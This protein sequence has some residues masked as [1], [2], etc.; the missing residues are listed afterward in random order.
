METDNSWRFLGRKVWHEQL[1]VGIIMNI[2]KDNTMSVR[3]L[4]TYPDLIMKP[5]SVVPIV[6]DKKYHFEIHEYIASKSDH[7]ELKLFPDIRRNTE[8]SLKCP[9]N[10]RLM[11]PVLG[12]DIDDM[13]ME[14]KE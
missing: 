10:E 8:K 4:F 12:T 7:P 11:S 2:Q 6:V 14:G 9:T 3:F 13:V 5:D 1:G